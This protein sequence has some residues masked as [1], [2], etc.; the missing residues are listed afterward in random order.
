MQKMITL[1]AGVHPHGS[2]SRQTRILSSGSAFSLLCCEH[3]GRERA[4]ELDVFFLVYRV[5]SGSITISPIFTWE[6]R[7]S[8]LISKPFFS[9]WSH[10]K[11]SDFAYFHWFYVH[12][13]RKS[14]FCD[15]LRGRKVALTL[16]LNHLFNRNW[17]RNTVNVVK[18]QVN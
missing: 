5:F 15:S 4:A 9:K 3:E 2:T 11:I 10:Y 17:P 13:H 8:K 12:L 1:F 14:I 16:A 18:P 7:R 6:I